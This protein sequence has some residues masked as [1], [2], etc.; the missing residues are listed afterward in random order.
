MFSMAISPF[1]ARPASPEGESRRARLAIAIATLGIVATLLAYAIS[2]GVRHAVSHAA[3]SVKHAVGH[4]LDNDSHEREHGAA[5]TAPAQARSAA[6][7]K[8]KAAPPRPAKT[9]PTKPVKH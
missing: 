2:P 3:H 5:K 9:A 8:A 1:S 7:A 4:V 6:S